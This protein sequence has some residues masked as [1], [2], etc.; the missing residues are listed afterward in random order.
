[1]VKLNLFIRICVAV[2]LVLGIIYVGSLVNF[3]FNPIIS[4]FNVVIVPLMLAVFFYYLLRPLIDYLS[5]RKLNRSLAILLVYLVIAVLLLGFTVGVW[6]SLRN[7]LVNVV[8]NMPGVLRAVGDQLSKLENSELLSNL[9]PENTNLSSQ[10]M[11]YL[12]KGFS[13][14]TVYVSGLFAFVS[15]F[16]IV[17][18]TFPILLFYMLKEG[19]KFGDKLVSFFLSGIMR[20]VRELLL[21]ST[22]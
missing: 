13:L 2:L 6:P 10:L 19:G 1:M 7:Q 17:L 3:I 14:A 15:N 4:L 21:K 9:I 18:F 20:R 12:N 11:D 16:A 8:N 22:E 5:S